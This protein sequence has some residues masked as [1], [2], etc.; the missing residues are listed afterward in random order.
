MVTEIQAH[1]FQDID[2]NTRIYPLLTSENRR[3]CAL[4]PF[5]FLEKFSTWT[6]AVGTP[7][8]PLVGAPTDIRAVKN[9]GMPGVQDNAGN[10]SYLR[11]DY[12][13]KT[14][15][16]NSYL[17]ADFPTRYN[18]YGTN[19]T[20]G[21]N[22]YVYPY[23]TASTLFALDYYALPPVLGAGTTEAQ[24]L[25]PDMYCPILMD[26]VLARLSR[27][28]GDLTDG[29]TYEARAN[30]G[31]SEMMMSFEVNQDSPDPMLY[32]DY[33]DYNF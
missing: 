23:I 2:A 12:I 32:T 22:L 1:D 33:D 26:R 8:T 21:M 31:V 11:R 28:E 4:A 27:A 29:D 20:G 10:L 3:L 16:L 15:G 13:E 18:L 24:L 19:S 14:F 17:L 6:E 25:L 9:M 7:A 5:P 30:A